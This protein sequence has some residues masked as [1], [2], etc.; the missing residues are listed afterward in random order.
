MSI[1]K[2]TNV[3]NFYF[4][5]LVGLHDFPTATCPLTIGD[6]ILFALPYGSN[7]KP[8]IE[9][10][11]HQN[12]SY[13]GSAYWTRGEEYWKIQAM[14]DGKLTLFKER[15]KMPDEATAFLVQLFT[16]PKLEEN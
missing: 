2:G 16:K 6:L 9:I 11:L 5:Y 3:K 14:I 12:D 8:G 4:G 15:F 13:L 1:L 10:R 7:L